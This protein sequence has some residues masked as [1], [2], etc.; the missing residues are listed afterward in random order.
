MYRGTKVADTA[1]YPSNGQKYICGFDWSKQFT[2]SG[3]VEDPMHKRWD[4]P[5]GTVLLTGEWFT[6]RLDTA[7][8]GVRNAVYYRI[9]YKKV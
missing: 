8:T 7:G 2:T 5:R 6:I 9:Y 4:A 3:T 1:V